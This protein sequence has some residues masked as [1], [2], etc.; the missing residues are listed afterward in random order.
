V[1][2]RLREEWREYLEQTRNH[3][4]IVEQLFLEMDLD[5]ETETPGRQVV[6]HIGESLVKAME[7]ARGAGKLEAAQLVPAE[8]VVL[9]ETKDQGQTQSTATCSRFSIVFR[10]EMSI[11]RSS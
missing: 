10:R 2:E 9:A 5:V 7:M 4:R 6:W 3:V 1:N 8:C 11:R